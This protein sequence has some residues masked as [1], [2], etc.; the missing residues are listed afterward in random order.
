MDESY[1]SDGSIEFRVEEGFSLPFYKNGSLKAS[2]TL[3]K[4]CDMLKV[5]IIDDGIDITNY[6]H[7]FI[8]NGYEYEHIRK[9]N[10]I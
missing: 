2:A 9:M 6:C 3:Q 8:S 4:V 10:I 7:Q 5:L 1:L